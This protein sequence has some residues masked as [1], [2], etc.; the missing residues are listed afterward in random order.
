MNPQ[1]PTAPRRRFPKA[2]RP[3]ASAVV[4]SVVGIG[5]ASPALGQ[6][7]PDPTTMPP[8]V[9]LGQRVKALKQKIKVRPVLVLVKNEAEFAD[10]V[11]SW[12][13]P[14]ECFPVLIDDGS[15]LGRENIARFVHAFLPRVIVRWDASKGSKEAWPTD[16][17]ARAERVSKAQL[18][19]WDAED[20]KGMKASWSEVGHEGVGIVL[21]SPSDPAWTAAL[22]LSAM[23]GQFL[24]WV[25]PSLVGGGAPGDTMAPQ[26]LASL[27]TATEDAAKATEAAWDDT[28]DSIEAI[29]L[30]ANA[31]SKIR[32]IGSGG[33]EQTMALTDR[34]GRKA[35]M[36]RW[37]YAGEIFGDSA[38]AAYR[39][40]SSAFLG[41]ENVWAFDGYSAGSVPGQYNLK[42]II[43][44]LAGTPVK[45]AFDPARSGSNEFRGASRGGVD[46]SLL[47]V[48]T[49]GQM[50]NFEFSPGKLYSFDVPILRS[51]ALV[52][53]TH[54]FSAQ[55]VHHRS[56]VAGRWLENG[57]YGYYGSVDEPYLSAFVAGPDFFKRFF[58]LGGPFAC[59]ARY[60][61]APLGKLNLFG[62]PLQIAGA[63]SLR[64]DEIL[65]ESGPLAGLVPINESVRETL[66]AGKIEQAATELVMLGRD[67]DAVRLCLAGLKAKAADGK[68]APDRTRLGA[69]GMPA[70][71]RDRDPAS[72]ATLC[73]AMPESMRNDPYY[74][75]LLWQA[76]RPV[77]NDNPTP[78]LLTAMKSAIRELCALEDLEDL[79]PAVRKAEGKPGVEAM[80]KMVIARTTD[81]KYRKD[82]EESLRETLRK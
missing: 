11:A 22:A 79:S 7:T 41:V 21:G 32:G 82:L 49:K 23:R 34:L 70:A 40:M 36:S 50:W 45:L 54:S 53:F 63:P 80:W 71:F 6:G 8:P 51:P 14:R 17:A 81:A 12:K 59:S 52:H 20:L 78:E 28:G 19:A 75:S 42:P 43:V 74:V 30:C 31:P 4:A 1:K 56:S 48:N 9:K 61:V 72:L 38:T 68:P 24:S 27:I 37:A 55:V 44:M 2:L 58:L 66:K 33:I 60:E 69:I 64:L 46:A 77:L 57:A 35:D 25:D 3:L 18:E 47:Y 73:L 39:A 5:C 65:P 76:G 62:D 67:K 13:L 29:T 10:A 16:P 26:Q 15:D